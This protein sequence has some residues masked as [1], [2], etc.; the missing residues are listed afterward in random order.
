[1]SQLEQQLIV[2]VSIVLEYLLKDFPVF[3]NE[4]YNCLSVVFGDV[5]GLVFGGTALLLLLLESRGAF[6]VG[7]FL[8]FF[9][10]LLNFCAR[11]LLDRQHF[12][13]VLVIG[14]TLDAML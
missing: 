10:L 13:L 14:S 12:C 7:G 9:G 4:D 3:L 2:V 6:E 8:M 11:L 5:L 1:V